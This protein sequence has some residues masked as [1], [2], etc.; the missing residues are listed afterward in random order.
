M[1]NIEKIVQKFNNRFGPEAIAKVLGMSNEGR[2]AILFGG[3][4]CLTCGM[5]DYFIDFL[6][7]LNGR[8]NKKYVIEDMRELDKQGTRWVVIYA[9][10]EI[11]RVIERKYR[12]II[13]DKN[14][15]QKTNRQ[16]NPQTLSS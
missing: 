6:E 10:Q 7:L 13:L 5:S 11:A 1:D 4:M 3:A 14:Q 16:N 8:A 12:Y 9:P 15:T 2:I